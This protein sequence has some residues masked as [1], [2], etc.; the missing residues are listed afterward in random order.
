M[1]RLLETFS[2]YYN[3]QDFR[4]FQNTL[5]QKVYETLGASYSNSDG[6]V[7]MVTDLCKALEGKTYG[8]LKFHATKIHGSRSFVEF[9]NQDKPT[10]KEL[11]D[12]VIISVAT[13]NRDIVYEKT[14]FIQNKKE[15]TK[16]VWKIDQD[17]LY[18]LHNFPTFKGEK[19]IFRKNFND[20]VVFQNHSETLGNYGLLQ[21]PG[22]MV[23]VN[24]LTVFRF[25]QGGKILFSD[26]RKYSHTKN[27]NFSF[28]LIDY[29]FW[30]EMLYRYFKHF[31]KYSFPFLN[32]PFL[33]NSIVSFNIYEFIRNWSLFNIGEVVSVCDKV[34]NYD[35]W[36]FNRILLRNA[37]LSEFINLK[38]ERQEHEFDNN[39]A[40]MVVHLNLDDEKR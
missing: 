5:A 33:G 14:A 24:A 39:L 3:Q 4:L 26:V 18:L 6:E 15:D 21:S 8:R 10:T 7:K 29:P 35:L 23:L 19:G 17:Q 31:P 22:E 36:N 32:L 37:G 28:P 9:H 11:A 13:K 20:E 25:Q 30:D 1:N 34:A 2:D 40:I 27:N 12:M 16:N 38:T